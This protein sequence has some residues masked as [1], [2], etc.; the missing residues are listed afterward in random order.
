MKT[1]DINTNIS[2]ILVIGATGTQGGKVARELLAHGHRIRILTR[3]PDA[4]AAQKLLEDGA[5]VV[6][7]DMG[8]PASLDEAL[9]GVS[10]VFSMS[11]LDGSGDDSEKRYAAL[12]VEAA[13][14]ADVD[15]FVH[16]SVAGIERPPHSSAPDTLV[17]Y[18]ND[19][20]EIEEYVRNAGF[21]GWTILRPTWIMENLAVPTSLFMFPQLKRGQLSTALQADTHLD[22]V[23][24]DDIGA[25]ARAIFD[26]PAP[27]NGKNI[28]LAGESLTMGEV[29]AVI[30][31]VLGKEVVSLSLSPAEAVS[32]GM[33]PSVVNSQ[34]YRNEV[35]FQVDIDALKLYGIPL[36]TFEQWV[37]KYRNRIVID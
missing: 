36:T 35:G 22:M 16:A 28:D 32:R 19:K 6:R 29:A 2:L 15:H 12:L 26:N 27:F 23:A 5:E 20:W 11:P 7:G 34:N 17:H 9:R 8:D 13:L 24:A 18:W 30:S 21:T 33:H 25:F 1:P 37:H 10:G 3:N 14:K 31:E 4:P